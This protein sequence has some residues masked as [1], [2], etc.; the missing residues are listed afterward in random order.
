MICRHRTPFFT[1]S[2]YIYA[3]QHWQE[4]QTILAFCEMANTPNS[5]RQ[6]NIDYNDF[7]TEDQ[8]AQWVSDGYSALKEGKRLLVFCDNG[9]F[10]SPIIAALIQAVY[11]Q[12]PFREVVEQYHREFI[13]EP[14]EH[15][16]WP[17]TNWNTA[18]VAYIEKH[19]PHL[20]EKPKQ[21]PTYPGR[22]P[23]TLVEYE[24]HG[25]KALEL[26]LMDDG[27]S[28]PDYLASLYAYAYDLGDSPLIVEIGTYYGNSAIV[29]AHAVKKKGG[30]V[31]SIDPALR[32]EGAQVIDE[33]DLPSKHF[34][35]SIYDIYKDIAFQKLDSYIT[36]IPDYS[37]HVLARWD[38]RQISALFV[39]GAH[40]YREVSKDCRW[41]QHIKLGGYAAFD[42][43]LS[44]V[45]QAIKE[46][47]AH[48]PEWKIIYESTHQRHDQYCV[49]ILKKGNP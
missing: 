31:I 44:G 27:W 23:Q 42:D 30:H 16:W 4:Y 29:M 14:I 33:D 21:A 46:Y 3:S 34:Q 32:A 10:K 48:K 18:I 7:P 11:E 39:D 19:Y 24:Y 15:N 5:V 20:K 49:T 36:L 40:S 43:Y 28:R 37:E 38:G 26:D 25:F 2:D 8:I 45:E 6:F 35:S 12:R 17:S 41:M 47:I 22:F 1:Q 13:Q 9:Q